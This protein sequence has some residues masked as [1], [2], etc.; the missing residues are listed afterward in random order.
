MAVQ[1]DPIKPTSKAHGTMRLKLKYGKLHSKFAFKIK[2]RCYTRVTMSSP[3]QSPFD[4]P[5]FQQSLGQAVAAHRPTDRPASPPPHL[6]AGRQAAP[7]GQGLTL[8]HVR[9]Q[10]KHFLWDRGCV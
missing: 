1:V 4:S 6:D 2:L 3:L 10:R 8:V 7:A 5:A 9:A